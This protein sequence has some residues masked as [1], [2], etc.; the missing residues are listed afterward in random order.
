MAS[1]GIRL[2]LAAVAG[3]LLLGTPALAK[4]TLDIVKERGRLVCGTSTGIAGFSMA[5]DKGEW[6]GLDVDVCRALAAAIFDDPKK[7]DFVPLSS[8]DRLVA[9]QTGEIDVLPRTT[10]WT[11]GRDAGIG[12]DFTAVNYYDGQG[13]QVRRDLGVES[14]R[15]L[16]GASICTVQ[17]TTNELNLADYF[18]VNNM[19]YQLVTFQSIDDT[20]KA[21]ES[22]RCDALTTDMS[23][24]VSYRLKMAEPDAHMLLPG[25][26]SKEP[27]G[28]YVRQGDDEWFDIVRWTVFAMVNAE[29]LGVT[30]ANVD[31]LAANSDNP[32]IRRLLGLDG[33]FGKTL[34]L[35]NDW[36]ARIVR[37]VGNYGESF[38][39]N[40][41]TGSPMQ[42]PRGVNALWSQ[43]GIQFAPP[44]R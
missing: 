28:P 6:T 30:K 34:G 17:G 37:H 24:L 2:A 42:L 32:E 22:K 10:T 5:D 7:A 8:K 25:V 21:Y 33:E 23:Q 44:I 38:D 16:N 39:R 18:R 20:V 19:D 40:L 43:G 27:L 11:L 1:T 12:L 31:E 36:V 9:L 29:E 15:E 4:G 26:I 3:T 13:F 41:G 14:I 35:T